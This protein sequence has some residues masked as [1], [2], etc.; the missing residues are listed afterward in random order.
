MKLLTPLALL[1]ALI[2]TASAATPGCGKSPTTIKAGVNRVTVNGKQREW[3]LALPSDYD[4]TKPYRL[5][6]AL[7][8]MTGTMNDVANGP[9]TNPYY[10]LQAEANGSAIFVSPNGLVGTN[11]MTG[12]ANTGGEDITFMQEILKATNAELCIN[13]NLR[14]ST[15]FSYGGAMS[16]SIACTLAKDF[17]AVAIQSGSLLSGCAGGTDAVAYYIQHGIS[18][19]VLPIAGGRSLRDVF[20]KNNGCT[21]QS[22]PEPAKG[23]KTHVLTKYAGCKEDKPLWWTAFDGDHTP[24]PTDGGTTNKDTTF[25][26]GQIWEFF[27]QFS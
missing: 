2:T 19:S 6:F 3:I 27:S 7:H 16:H 22:L 21:Q 15:G 23:S 5:I 25:T 8:W 26:T 17:R 14:F 1:S 12:W 24:I 20:V 9:Q 4:N 11:G 13:E 10:G 18:D